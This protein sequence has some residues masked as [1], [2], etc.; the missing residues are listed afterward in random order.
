MNPF[1]ATVALLSIHSNECTNVG[2]ALGR[3]VLCSAS[4][5][6]VRGVLVSENPRRAN[7]YIISELEPQEAPR[8]V[9]LHSTSK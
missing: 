2:E 5:A 8:T 6:P 1:Q 3:M 7:T 9:W 4:Q